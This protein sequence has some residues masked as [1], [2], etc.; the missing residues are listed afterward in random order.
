MVSISLAPIAKV[1]LVNVNP[2]GK[3]KKIKELANIAKKSLGREIVIEVL[4]L[5]NM[6]QNLLYFS[7]KAT[8]TIRISIL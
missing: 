3:K 4:H 2:K 8:K 6:F 1:F 7:Q 5:G